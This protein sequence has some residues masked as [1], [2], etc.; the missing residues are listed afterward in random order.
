MEAENTSDAGHGEQV[1]MADSPESLRREL[2]EER[3]RT[4]RLLADFAN[5]RRRVGRERDAARREGTRD[6]LLPVL[7]VLDNLERALTAGSM[8]QGFYDGIVAI[9]RLFVAALREAGAEPIE[10]VG[11]PFDPAVH[12][13]VATTSGDATEAG[14]VMRETRRGWRLDGHL[15]RP[16]RVVVTVAS[17]G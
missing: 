12:E 1:A 13:A 2:E 14:L 8:D 7:P 16:A 15:L 9:H 11:Q 3:G 10:A 6:A 5:F 4:L 17:S